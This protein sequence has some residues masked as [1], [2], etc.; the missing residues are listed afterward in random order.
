M[1]NI[2]ITLASAGILGLI[3]FGLTA[4]VTRQRVATKVI[5]GD[6]DGATGTLGLRCAIR[7]HGNF[8]EYVPLIL[9]LLGGSE[10]AGAPR[11]LILCL[12]VALILARLSHAFGIHLPAPNP[13]R[14]GGAMLTWAVLLVAAITAIVEAL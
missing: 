4:N 7:A 6:G 13:L 2:P 12:A 8:V 1:T 10:A 3:F 11:L 5:L 9:I 14:A